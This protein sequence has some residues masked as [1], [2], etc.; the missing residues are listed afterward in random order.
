[1]RHRFSGTIA[2]V[3]TTSGRR[4]VVGHW[5]TSP[6]GEFADV[7][8]EDA[9]GRRTL[10]APTQQVA[11][12]VAGTYHF[13][14]VRVVPVAAS[15]GHVTAGPLTLSYDLGGR[16]PLGRLLRL[17]PTA[18]WFAALVDPVARVVLKGVRT[19]VTAKAGDREWYAA[20]DQHRISSAV[21]TWDGADCGALTD[22]VPPVRFGPGSTPPKPS[23][24]HLVS[25]V[26]RG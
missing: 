13:D 7:M 12:F 15:P 19:R 24:V 6:F 2:G 11:D 1:M 21:V 8:V 26:E 3:G 25:T 4:V 5:T 10:L 17:T 20:R 16:T 18:P 22:V 14:E 9:A 23:V